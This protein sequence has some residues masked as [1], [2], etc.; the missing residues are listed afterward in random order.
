MLLDRWQ[1][2][3][4]LYHSARERSAEERQAYLESACQ[5]DETVRRE[6]ESLL[7]NDDLAVEFLE[8]H[9]ETPGRA[10]GAA[11]PS[12]ERIGPYVVLEFLRAGGMGEV[13]KARDTRL[14]RTVAIKFLPRACARDRVAL[15][16]FQRE[17]RAASALNHPRIC[18]LHDVGEHQGRPFLVMEYLEGQSLKDRLARKPMDAREL[19]NLAV[20]ICDALSAAHARGIVHRDIKP[21]N[22]FITR[23]TGSG[24]RGQIKILDFGLAKLGA[25]PR[26]AP[27]DTGLD[28]DQTVSLNAL[29]RPGSVMGTLAYLSPEQARGEE[30]DSRTDIFSF[31]VVLYEM[32]AGTPAFHGKT[33][34]EL[35]GAILETAPVKPSALNPAIPR[36]LERIILK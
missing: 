5:G 35:I 26:S 10:P 31:G 18:T 23:P 8:T 11:I 12:D 6:V 33:S 17:A 19:L 1:E 13:Y 30:V 25:E 27:A 32:A 7:A 9:S 16:R 24:Q 4:S 15:D 3:E 20:Q 29:T 2:I 34:R 21:A 14:D 28:L 22:I 36:G